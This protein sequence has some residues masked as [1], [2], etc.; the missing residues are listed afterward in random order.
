MH[1]SH[2]L[3]G[4]GKVSKVATEKTKSSYVGSGSRRSPKIVASV[5][6]L[7]HIRKHLGESQVVPKKSGVTIVLNEKGEQMPTCLTIGWRVCI[8]YRRLNEV[9]RKDHF[10]LPFKDQLLERISDNPFY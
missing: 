3:G 5:Y 8:D 9:T 1:L 4:G 2:L 10:P 7:P 6:N